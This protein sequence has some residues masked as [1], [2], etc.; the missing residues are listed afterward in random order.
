MASTGKSKAT[1][2]PK[3]RKSLQR[4]RTRRRY[5]KRS[6]SSEEDSSSDDRC[7]PCKRCREI[8]N[9]KFGHSSDDPS[10]V[11]R[12]DIF[13]GDEELRLRVIHYRRI[14]KLSGGF[15][16]D[17]I[18]DIGYL[19]PRPIDHFRQYR[20]SHFDEILR[21]SVKFVFDTYR[22]KVGKELNLL[23]ILNVTADVDRYVMAYFT[24]E[25]YNPDAEGYVDVI[26][27]LVSTLRYRRQ[28][29]ELEIL[30]RVTN[31]DQDEYLLPPDEYYAIA[32]KAHAERRLD[33]WRNKYGN[34]GPFY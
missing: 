29:H 28:E 12:S 14:M 15:D 4:R 27:A 2:S 1:A 22:E 11:K 25:C 31:D 13:N 3:R 23:R 30:R 8:K 33:I 24:F 26:Q 34:D 5:R 6:E 16:A 20:Y 21:S 7:K 18:P 19:G 32:T 9:M 10:F 17:C